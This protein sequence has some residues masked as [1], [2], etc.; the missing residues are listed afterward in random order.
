MA[1]RLIT[2]KTGK[3]LSRVHCI[4]FYIA[5]GDNINGKPYGI[6]PTG[7]TDPLGLTLDNDST[8]L[9]VSINPGQL[10]CYGR[11]CIITEKTQILDMHDWPYSS[12]CFGTVYLRID[13]TDTVDQYC[14]FGLASGK[15]SYVDFNESQ[16]HSNLY[17]RSS[18]IYDVPIARFIFDPSGPDGVYF[19]KYE[20][21]IPTLDEQAR[22]GTRQVQKIGT[23][24]VSKIFDNGTG[25]I[26]AENA[27]KATDATYFNDTEIKSDL[28]NVWTGQRVKILTH[29]A[30]NFKSTMSKTIPV[31]IDFDHLIK[32]FI[33]SE[34][35]TYSD[36]RRD[37]CLR[38]ATQVRLPTGGVITAS[39]D[40]LAKIKFN[41][42]AD[43]KQ[44]KKYYIYLNP[45][46][47]LSFNQ[48]GSVFWELGF[49]EKEQD[50]NLAIVQVVSTGIYWKGLFGEK[51]IIEE[52]ST[53]YCI[54]STPEIVTADSSGNWF[55]GNQYK[56]V[57]VDF[58]Y[59]GDVNVA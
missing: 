17:K 7:E 8:K 14:Y 48:K 10:Y 21:V 5:K 56:S 18:G 36:I 37:V 52:G 38:F 50:I 31:K 1:I 22:A 49:S 41:I 53:Y 6:I 59:K 39:A 51:Y 42:D 27:D 23:T 12:K 30:D 43:F 55:Y 13:L 58:L 44:Q 9:T 29:S 19:S 34:H 35:Y 24:S 40:V 16:N 20:K 47:K 11:Q 3:V 57:Y 25:I 32:A 54:L 26:T 46:S 4:M 33:I 45:T 2:K 15:E 28:T